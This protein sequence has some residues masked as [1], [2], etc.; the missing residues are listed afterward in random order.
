MWPWP[1]VAVVAFPLLVFLS[2]YLF[3][4]TEEVKYARLSHLREEGVARRRALVE[5]SRKRFEFEEQLVRFREV[6]VAF[7]RHPSLRVP[8]SVLPAEGEASVLC[9]G[10]DLPVPIL[11]LG[12]DLSGIY[13]TLSFSRA[14][15]RTFVPWEA[16]VGTRG[17]G[18]LEPA[19]PRLELVP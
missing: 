1:I 2:S 16:V 7:V 6:R 17:Y 3:R 10:L 9:Y 14:P 5:A 12:T 8:D 4:V 11:D 19:R 15:C 18:E 13:A